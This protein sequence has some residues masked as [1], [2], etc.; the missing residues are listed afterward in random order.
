METRPPSEEEVIAILLPV[1]TD[2]ELAAVSQVEVDRRR[3]VPL[4]RIE[5]LSAAERASVVEAGK[6]SLR[7]RGYVDQAGRPVQD[8]ALA[9]ILATRASPASLVVAERISDREK[10]FLYGQRD[11]G[12]L[13]ERVERGLHYFRLLDV[14]GA[15]AELA[16][17]ADPE[18][19]A[20]EDGPALPGDDPAPGWQ[21]R[22]EAT[23]A[24]ADIVTRVFAVRGTAPAR[25][26]EVVVYVAAQPDGV[27]ALSALAGPEGGETAV[28]AKQVS[29]ATL[30]GVMATCLE[31]RPVEGPA[32][33]GLD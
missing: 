30:A 28:S 12:F 15:A 6:R 3:L 19:W 33:E 11:G 32:A 29:A 9:F 7:A 13:E 18:S 14:E 26:D 23:I 27:W 8:R 10:R 21:T 5:S 22:V 17:F 25:T 2:E 24:G 20:G 1:F 4:E 16:A 31:L